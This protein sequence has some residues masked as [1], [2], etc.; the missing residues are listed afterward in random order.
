MW[1]NRVREKVLGFVR[2]GLLVGLTWYALFGGE[3]PLHE[4]WSMRTQHA[5]IEAEIA[6]L[7]TE[8]DSLS[9]VRSTL[10]TDP[11]FIERVAREKFGLIK[12]GEVLYRFVGP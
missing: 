8:I 2:M 4:L 11:T 5:T 9:E 3:Y 1:R 10:E 12:N 7:R 6:H